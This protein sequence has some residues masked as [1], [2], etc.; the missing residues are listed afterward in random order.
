MRA[1][2]HYLQWR[3]FRAGMMT[4]PG[5]ECGGFVDLDGDGRADLQV[6]CSPLLMG[7]VDRQPPPGHGLTINTQ[8]VR[9]RSRGVVRLRSPKAEDP[10]AF[11]GNYLS[12]PEDVTTLIRGVRLA[13]RLLQAPS[14]RAVVTRPLVLG[15]HE[16]PTDS[17]IEDYVREYAKTV[18]HPAGTCRMGTD[19]M[20]VV[21]PRLAVR[22]IEHLHVGDA[23]V[24][25]AL[26]SGNTN[27]TT[28]MIAERC[29]EY[30]RRS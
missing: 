25:P 26:P 23:S 10:I 19:A 11:Q 6:I 4:S 7:D 28:V 17:A 29:A 27:A 21:D 8:T 13:R 20:S 18:F 5:A 9:P 3:F 24:M 30:L 15:S 16:D 14:L 12:A 2:R 1:L 22:G